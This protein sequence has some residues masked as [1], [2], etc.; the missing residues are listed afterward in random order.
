MDTSDFTLVLLPEILNLA[1]ELT[2]Q[3][4]HHRVELVEPT[5]A[6][7]FVKIDYVQHETSSIFLRK[8]E[9]TKI[10]QLKKELLSRFPDAE[11]GDILL[12]IR[13]IT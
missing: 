9:P 2:K 13:K 10:E 6:K 7:L 1:I 11:Y 5:E 12:G 3:V 8:Y 4:I